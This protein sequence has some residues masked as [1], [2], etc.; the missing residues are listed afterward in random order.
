MIQ[1]ES[2]T[3]TKH[4]EGIAETGQKQSQQCCLG[5]Q[6]GVSD[7]QCAVGWLVGAGALII[8]L[9]KEP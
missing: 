4:V 9:K 5:R 1:Q 2:S 6:K 3:S 8:H 7:W